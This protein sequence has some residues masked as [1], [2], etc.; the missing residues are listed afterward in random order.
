LD[1]SLKVYLSVIAYEKDIDIASYNQH[2]IMNDLKQ[3]YPFYLLAFSFLLLYLF[4]PT[5]NSTIDSY[6]YA[7]SVRYGQNLLHPHH[8]LYSVLGWVLLSV[9]RFFNANAGALSV[10]KAMNAFV[11][12]SSLV[13][14]AEILRRL[15][16]GKKEI[17]FI[18][19]IC[20]SC[21]GFCRFATEN[22]N[23]II[24]IF[25]SLLASLYFLK[26]IQKGNDLDVFFAGL[27]AAMACLFHV[28]HFFWWLGLLLGFAIYRHKLRAIALYILPALIVPFTYMLLLTFVLCR[29]FSPSSMTSYLFDIFSNGQA[30]THVGL[31]NFYLTV[32][33]FI[34]TFF[35]VHG[36]MLFLLR[37][38]LLF[39]LPAFISMVLIVAGLWKKVF[40]RKGEISDTQNFAIIIGIVFTLQFLFA[41]FSKGNA[42]FMVMLPFLL[43]I[44]LSEFFTFFL[45]PLLCTGM[46]LLLWNFSYGLYPAR[47]YKMNGNEE[48]AKFIMDKSDALFIMNDAN[49]LQNRLYY[50]TGV[51]D[52]KNIVKLPLDEQPSKAFTN[53]IAYYT[54]HRKEVY[55][56]ATDQPVGFNR[57]ALVNH[58][59]T[60]LLERYKWEKAD[61][62]LCLYGET[63]LYRLSR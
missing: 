45:R 26:F 3:N 37:K 51:D 60:K 63:Y 29:P 6:G 46:A 1:T 32:I 40:K 52:V 59:N 28:S 5:H 9:C 20:G 58:F 10:L 62:I 50:L 39:L 8:L 61:S 44:V 4:F 35:Q 7:A 12:A 11:A 48:K 22:E 56:D 43:M 54:A 23:Y 34:R 41:F 17:L 18:V 15:N 16:R 36:Y 47:F 53:K 27:L 57:N 21:F 42:E 25:I 19:L 2:R 24:P 30:D 31:D 49:E 14:F 55:A 38:S 13:V 33:G